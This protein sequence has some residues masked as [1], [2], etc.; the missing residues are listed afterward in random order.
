[1]R[2]TIHTPSLLVEEYELGD[3]FRNN[4]DGVI[5][6]A[7]RR[8]RPASS[9]RED[10]DPVVFSRGGDAFDEA[11]EQFAEAKEAF[12][13]AKERAKA[14]AIAACDAGTLSEHAAAQQLGVDRL[15]IRN[16][17]GKGR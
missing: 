7:V 11:A 17:R 14:A 4:N 8:K 6:G 12:E 13:A 3:Q 1:M 10:G 9:V 16:W 15:T 5:L 2:V